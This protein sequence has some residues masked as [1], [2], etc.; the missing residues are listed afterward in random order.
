MAVG[1][2]TGLTPGADSVPK[3]SDKSSLSRGTGGGEGA[4]GCMDNRTAERHLE[5]GL[6]RQA[7]KIRVI[8]VF[9][10][11]TISLGA[12]QE[13]LTVPSLAYTSL[14][15]AA[16]VCVWSLFF[17]R[18][19]ELL[20][21]GRLSLAVA[22]LSL[23]DL[24]WLTLFVIGTGGADSPFWALLLL[25]VVFAGAFF[26]DASW[27]LPLTAFLVAS[28]YA[29]L[30]GAAGPSDLAMVWTLSGRLLVVICAAWFTWGLASVLER[31]RQ[32]NQ[33]IVR[34]L[35][36][37]VLLLNSDG[38]VLLANPR[39]GQ[40]CGLPAEELVGRNLETLVQS[41]GYALLRQ[42]TTDLISRPSGVMTTE[43]VVEGK[44]VH[45]LRC[46]T[47]PCR[48]GERTLGW[49]LI[50]QDIT[51]IKAQAR[52]KEQGLGLVSHELR[53]PLASLRVMAQLLS[54]IS[55]EL[56]PAERDRVASTIEHE[57]D[58][59]SRLVAGLLDLARLEQ[60]DFV[61]QNEEVHLGRLARQVADL[62][63]P[64]AQLAGVELRM[65]VPEELPTIRGDSDRLMQVLTNLVDNAIKYTPT[66]GTV[67]LGAE[68]PAGQVRVWV[69][70]TGRG[71]PDEAR[72]L[73]FQKFGQLPGPDRDRS[74]SG[75]G[76]GLY[77]ARLIALKHG[78]DLWV[79]SRVGKGS[80]FM[81]VLPRVMARPQADEE[82]E[83]ASTG[84]TAA[85]TG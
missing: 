11:A 59:L 39:L 8:L 9:F 56:T 71:I 65:E 28:I 54:G 21:R 36:E 72:E 10:L 82:A 44:E 81:L 27:S 67:T 24:G 52:L 19:D 79:S 83:V 29:V 70:D 69:R 46:T 31:E 3:G 80:T 60:A 50:V 77:V 25:V 15:L 85:V 45:D 78:G 30:A 64:T 26:S 7:D 6:I 2:R 53:S 17:L 55:G 35:T 12:G 73:I 68:A 4:D 63:T 23:F 66:G 1:S 62:F 13:M 20:A 58:R 43:L 33:R 18:W 48:G 14:A 34:H 51:D 5:F 22:L 38:V 49:V 57:T 76:L 40:L 37:G 42:L 47:V 84:E 41:P 61:L 32:A 74:E 16:L 75:V